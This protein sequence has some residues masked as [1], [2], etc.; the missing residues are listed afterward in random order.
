MFPQTALLWELRR[1]LP[2][3]MRRTIIFCAI[4]QVPTTVLAYLC[5]QPRRCTF[6]ASNCQVSKQPQQATRNMLLAG[7]FRRSICERCHLLYMKQYCAQRRYNAMGA[8]TS[9]ALRHTFCV[10]EHTSPTAPGGALGVGQRFAKEEG[11]GRTGQTAICTSPTVRVG[12][13]W[14]PCWQD[15]GASGKRP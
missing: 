14:S 3:S 6:T 12:I 9:I 13:S 4:Q 11:D 15:V 10:A 2:Q 8:F 1:T 7:A 5:A